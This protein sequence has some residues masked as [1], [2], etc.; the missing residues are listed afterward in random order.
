MIAL[1][2]L[3]KG[4]DGFPD[5]SPAKESSVD[6]TTSDEVLTVDDVAV[7]VEAPDASFEEGTIAADV[8]DEDAANADPA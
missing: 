1:L 4:S 5:N 7:L 6:V 8:A 2:L 3:H